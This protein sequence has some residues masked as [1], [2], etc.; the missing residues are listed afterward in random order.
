[1]ADNGYTNTV[2]AGGLDRRSGITNAEAHRIWEQG[3]EGERKIESL[4]RHHG[5]DVENINEKGLYNEGYD[6]IVQKGDKKLFIECKTQ[7]GARHAGTMW[8]WPYDTFF[9]ET[10]HA[11]GSPSG[12]CRPDNHITT[13]FA[14]LNLW[15]KTLYIFDRNCLVQLTASPLN[16]RYKDGCR[17]KLIRWRDEKAG[18]IKAV[19]IKD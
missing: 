12:W 19:A 2:F 1:M 8:E 16:E 3:A 5:W 13:H 11:G 9:C 6:L 17:G 15:D 18:F 10:H 7:A 4:F 14:V